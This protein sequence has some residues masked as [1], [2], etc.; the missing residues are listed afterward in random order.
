MKA[1]IFKPNLFFQINSF[2]NRSKA[3]T[4]KLTREHLNVNKQIIDYAMTK[5]ILLN[6][7]LSKDIPSPLEVY[8][9]QK[10]HILSFLF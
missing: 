9:I 1:Q 10:V 7:N 3:F 4:E 8:N 5:V 6:N 2:K